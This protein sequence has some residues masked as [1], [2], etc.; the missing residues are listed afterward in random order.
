MNSNKKLNE[1]VEKSGESSGEKKEQEGDTSYGILRQEP[2]KK[3]EVS[4]PEHSEF[5]PALKKTKK[6]QAILL[7]TTLKKAK[8][9]EIGKKQLFKQQDE[10]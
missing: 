9:T 8:E 7:P 3:N 6:K 10:K 2:L 1:R 5:A 4:T